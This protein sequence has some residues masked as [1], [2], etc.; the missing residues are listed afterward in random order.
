MAISRKL[1]AGVDVWLNTPAY[2]MEASGTSGEK[3]GIN[4]V[5]NLSVLDGWWAEGFNG[6]NGWGIM[7]HGGS[8]SDEF[9]DHAEAGELLEMVE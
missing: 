5:L 7:P 2:P 1:V 4:G 6:K 8:F 3:A 9:R